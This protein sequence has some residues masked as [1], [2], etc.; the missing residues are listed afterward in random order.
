MAPGSSPPARGTRHRR[1]RSRA[2]RRFIPARAGNTHTIW[3]AAP[4][5]PVHPRPRGEHYG[6]SRHG[7][8][9][10]GSSPPA[11]GTPSRLAARQT[12]RR[13]IPA[14]A[15]NTAA[16]RAPKCWRR[17]HPRPRGE[18]SFSVWRELD[19]TGSSPPARGT[20]PLAK[21]N[22]LRH[23]FIPARAGN[24][25][26]EFLGHRVSP[27]HPRPRGEH[28]STSNCRSG[29]TGSSP[30]ARGTRRF[31]GPDQV[32]ERFIPARAGNTW[33]PYSQRRSSS[34]HPRPRGEHREPGLCSQPSSGS[35]PPA[36]GTRRIRGRGFS[37]RWF[38][39]ARAGNTRS[40]WR[41]IYPVAVHPR[42]RGEHF[43]GPCGTEYR[44]G[45]SPPARG[46]PEE[47]LC[48]GKSSTVHP[49]P[50]GEHRSRRPTPGPCSG[51]SPPARGTLPLMATSLTAQRF[52]PARAGNT[53]RMT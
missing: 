36:R 51:S 47:H 12:L 44:T 42:P 20:Q 50:R 37:R 7:G 46:T 24:T 25:S 16:P 52:I 1:H 3:M 39:P 41:T 26:D 40:L 17:V 21:P 23:R 9:D 5:I 49:R 29:S 13:F 30:P 18:H 4:S 28:S 22:L 43:L 34:V 14:R 38:I 53:S 33:Q 8:A 45:S 31:A 32:D 10:R 48:Q 6:P 19:Y 11:R 15:G 2:S 27:V 35:S